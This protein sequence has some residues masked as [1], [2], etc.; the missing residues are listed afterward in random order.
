ME[1]RLIG[2]KVKSKAGVSQHT[3]ALHIPHP[4]TLTNTLNK[5]SHSEQ[6]LCVYMLF[7]LLLLLLLLIFYFYFYYLIYYFRIQDTTRA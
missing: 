5:L 3:V 6:N 4:Y 7:L 1:Q 2:W